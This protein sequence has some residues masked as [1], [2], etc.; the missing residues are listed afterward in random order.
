MKGKCYRSMSKSEK[1]HEMKWSWNSATQNRIPCLEDVHAK[2]GRDIV[3]IS[4]LHG[5]PGI[6]F[7][8]GDWWCFSLN[9]KAPT[10]P[11]VCFKRYKIDPQRWM[12]LIFQNHRWERN[13]QD[14]H[15]S[16][17][18]NERIIIIIIIIIIIN[19]IIP[20][21]YFAWNVL[22]CEIWPLKQSLSFIGCWLF[23]YCCIFID[24]FTFTQQIPEIH[25]YVSCILANK[26]HLWLLV[27]VQW[28]VTE[29]SPKVQ[30]V[31]ISLSR[32]A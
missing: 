9:F 30:T 13:Q 22:S 4:R 19:D 26:R 25:L 28:L 24:K 8:E 5:L 14:L 12:Q 27:V 3:I 17:S 20:S 32:P 1:P 11:V 6:E 2:P 10:N 15:H 21:H 18:N 23:L 7:Y 29:N 31:Q 16:A